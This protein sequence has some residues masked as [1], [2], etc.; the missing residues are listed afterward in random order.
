MPIDHRELH[1]VCAAMLL[2]IA[3]SASLAMGPAL[4]SVPLT[5]ALLV[6]GG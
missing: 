4:L 6:V 1:V 5:A 3:M 2:V